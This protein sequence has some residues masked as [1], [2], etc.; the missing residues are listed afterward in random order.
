MGDGGSGGARTHAEEGSELFAVSGLTGGLQSSEPD[1]PRPETREAGSRLLEAG[2][3]L[4]NVAHMLGQA[5]IA[6]TSI[7]STRLG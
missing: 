2:W 4:H 6:Q 3:P 1:V 5:N 7:I